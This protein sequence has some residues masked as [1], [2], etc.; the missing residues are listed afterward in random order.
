MKYRDVNIIEFKKNIL[1]PLTKIRTYSF[2][3]HKTLV[4]LENPGVLLAQPYIQYIDNVNALIFSLAPFTLQTKNTISFYNIILDQLSNNSIDI[5]CNSC[6]AFLLDGN[7]VLIVDNITKQPLKIAL[8]SY[9]KGIEI[10]DVDMSVTLSSEFLYPFHEFGYI[11]SN[12]NSSIYRIST[13]HGSIDVKEF[14][15]CKNMRNVVHGREK[16]TICLNDVDN[17]MLITNGIYSIEYRIQ[18]K[19]GYIDE[20][21][22]IDVKMLTNGVYIRF[23]KLGGFILKGGKN[24][25]R[26]GLSKD[27]EPLGILENGNIVGL[28]RNMLSIA[29][30]EGNSLINIAR[31]DS[32]NIIGLYINEYNN[33]ISTTY[34]DRI[35][36]FDVNENPIFIEIPY[37]KPL[38]SMPIDNYL[39]V[40]LRN[41]IRIYLIDRTSNRI[42]LEHIASLPQN[43][44]H[45]TKVSKTN[46]LCIDRA[47]RF[48]LANIE[49]IVKVLNSLE[50]IKVIRNSDSNSSISTILVSDYMPITPLK[51][52]YYQNLDYSVHRLDS[53]KAIIIIDYEGTRAKEIPVEVDGVLSHINTIMKVNDNIRVIDGY[54]NVKILHKIGIMNTEYIFI[55]PPLDHNVIPISL[56][57]TET[58]K[59]VKPSIIKVHRNENSL[60][61]I[62]ALA[63]ELGGIRSGI[64]IDAGNSNAIDLSN[65]VKMFPDRICVDKL[66]SIRV[67]IYCSNSVYTIKSGCTNLDRCHNLLA[68]HLVL[69]VN[70]N[71]ID[72]PLPLDKFVR[73][74]SVYKNELGLNLLHTNE[75]I[76]TI[77]STCISINNPMIIVENGSAILSISVINTCSNVYV[78]ILTSRNF[79]TLSP[80]ESKTINIQIGIDTLIRGYEYLALVEPGGNKI[81]LFNL[82]LDYIIALSTKTALKMF[83]FLGLKH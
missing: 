37:I 1:S 33:R 53:S 9:S 77:P 47:G 61:G 8:S 42:Y 46:I 74:R 24:I 60:G 83:N 45:C 72:V 81:F 68:I 43:L 80:H 17:I 29:D 82:P 25:T 39:M 50:N 49:R 79:Y 27:F 2:D 76:L 38:Y 48:V 34:N 71:S 11:A 22:P 10:R 19:D 35:M 51:F 26:I 62:I 70:R 78:N 32:D 55:D 59:I 63:K 56:A 73:V 4:Y 3:P 6:K 16:M 54:K 28:I 40:F 52:G 31:I 5:E 65:I 58:I 41:E 66:N 15:R 69:Y 64:I 75:F 7:S 57:N 21:M 67:K 20:V 23:E 12:T 44:V 18:K 30:P 36:L 14:I 13:R